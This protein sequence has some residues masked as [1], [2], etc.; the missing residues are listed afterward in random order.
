MRMLCYYI[1]KKKKR[2][3]WAA[4]TALDTIYLTHHVRK[5]IKPH[6]A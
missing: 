6:L 5:E 2:T 1:L 3:T 4:C